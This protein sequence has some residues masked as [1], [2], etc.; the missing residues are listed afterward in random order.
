MSYISIYIPIVMYG[1]R[2]FIV[3]LQEIQCLLQCLLDYIFV[4]IEKHRYIKFCLDH[5]LG[6]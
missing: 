5:L 1:L 6:Q 4:F 3:V 2:L